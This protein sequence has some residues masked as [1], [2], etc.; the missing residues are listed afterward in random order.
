MVVKRFW[1]QIHWFLGITAGVVL[2]VMGITG[3]TLSFEPDI[4]RLLN[5][6][7]M[8]VEPGERVLAPSELIAKAREQIPDKVVIGVTRSMAP[9]DAGQIGFEGGR[10][11]DWHYQ[12]PYT[13]ALLGKPERG[14]DFLHLMEDIHRRLAAGDTGKAITGASA[15]VL[16]LMCCTGLY[17]RWPRQLGNWRTWLTFSWAL[18]GRSFLW[19]M[20]AAVGTWVLIIYLLSALTGLYWSY[21]WYRNALYDLTGTPRPNP[22]AQQQA[23]A[24]VQENNQRGERT[25]KAPR[26]EIDVDSV[27]QA[28]ERELPAGLTSA[29]MRL[30]EKAGQPVEFRY[31]DAEPAHSRASNTLALQP[32]DLS[33]TKHERYA[34]LPAGGKLIRSMFV[35][36]TGEFFGLVGIIIMMIASALMPLFAISGWML[37]L[38]RRRKK[39]AARAAASGFTTANAAGQQTLISF[40]SQ[41]GFAEQLAWQTAGALQAAGVPVTVKPLAAIEREHLSQYD[42]ALFVVST[43]G[44]GE[45][46]DAAQG[47]VQRSMPEQSSLERLSFA[48]LALGDKQYETFCAFGRKLEQWLSGNGAKALFE[49]VEVDNGDPQAIEQ[50]RQHLQTLTKTTMPEIKAFADNYTSWRLSERHCLNEG[51]AGEAMFHLALQPLD[52]KLEWQAGDLVEVLPTHSE[53]T[54]SEWLQATGW[55]FDA[56]IDGEPL[57]QWLSKRDLPDPHLAKNW[58]LE[59]VSKRLLPL[60]PR[61]YSIASVPKDGSLWLLVRQSH[62]RDGKLGLASGWLT[63][64]LS[65]GDTLPLR[66]VRNERFH[67]REMDKPMILIGNGSGLSALRA[68]IRA[69]ELAGVKNNWLLFGERNEQFDYYYREE[70][71]RWQQSGVLT[72]VDVAFSRDQEQRVYVQDK[73][74]TAADELNKWLSNGAAIYICGSMVGM[75]QA[76]DQTLKQILGE[77]A[78]TELA[79]AGRYN[80]DVY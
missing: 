5:P 4:L 75:S 19:Q 60:R 20:H 69:R 65:I 16:I 50:W 23:P 14:H 45:A 58:K 21:D 77:A 24:Q 73:L 43:F 61:S 72:R 27:W 3:A 6:A 37:Y 26:P 31:L 54:V 66:V 40:A 2:A 34:D 9:N 10:R 13:G 47:F 29:T 42:K 30:P 64:Q 79:L 67:C 8:T 11:G 39:I 55:P 33:V 17:L 74:L 57:P 48:V 56:E 44:D 18:K 35:L 71:Q 7:V 25:E 62:R 80:R 38:D 53:Q 46:P 59:L 41:T 52:G 51:S 76:V 15:I 12:N 70:I 78:V 22:P 63:E 28:F 68:H 49:R 1:F 36:H 32:A